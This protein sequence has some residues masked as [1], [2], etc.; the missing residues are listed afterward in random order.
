MFNSFIKLAVPIFIFGAVPLLMTPGLFKL[1]IIIGVGGTL[2]SAFYVAQ[3]I[4]SG[5]ASR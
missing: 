5:D 2:W 1:I 4:A 3:G